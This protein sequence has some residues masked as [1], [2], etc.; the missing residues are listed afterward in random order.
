MIVGR[1]V[2]SD[3]GD[4]GTPAGRARW[5]GSLGLPTLVVGAYLV[6]GWWR[7]WTVDDAFINYRVVRQVLAGNGPV[8]NI[9]ERVEATTST[10]WVVVLTV[11]DVVS[12]FSIEWSALVVEVV[13][14][15]VGMAAGMAGAVRLG[16]LIAPDGDR[17]PGR[18][19]IV[20]PVGA[21][22]Y[23]AVAGAWDWATGGL[24][25][26]LGLAWLGVSFWAVVHLVDSPAT[27]GHLSPAG[28]DDGHG[29]IT[30]H[31]GG[32]R[33][34]DHLSDDGRADSDGDG[35]GDDRRV[36]SGDGEVAGG[37]SPR[38]LVLT[39]ALVGLGVL[40]RPDFAVFSAGFAVPV[41]AVVWRQPRQ[42][43]W[44]GFVLAAV[45]A[46]ALP[47]ATQVFRMGYY[48]QLVPNPLHAKESSR[49]WWSHGWDHL[50]DFTGTY[51][52]VV[53]V[54]VTAAWLVATWWT[55]AAPERHP[56]LAG[57][58]DGR[59]GHGPSG[60]S[61]VADGSDSHV[62][63]GD[64]SHVIDGGGGHG[65]SNDPGGGG[66]GRS[67]HRAGQAR[68]DRAGRARDWRLVVG[69]VEAAAAL[70]VLG[71]ARAGG[72]YMHARLLLPAWFALL[73]PLFA[74]RAG[75]LAP[76]WRAAAAL[77][78]GAWA[79]V[80]VAAFRP[81]G[82]YDIRTQLIAAT[83]PNPV[84]AADMVRAL[85]PLGAAADLPGPGYHDFT[86]GGLATYPAA[87]GRTV[88]GTE[89][90]G[91]VGLS[92]PLDVWVHDR[93]GLADPVTARVRL[94]HRGRPGHE[95]ILAGPWIAAM[96]VD[97]SVPLPGDFAAVNVFAAQSAGVTT[98][99]RTGFGA[100]RAAA[101]A[102]LRCGELGEL[103]HDTRAPLDVGRFVGNVV[104]AVKLH[105]ATFPADPLAARAELC[106]PSDTDG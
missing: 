62:A 9:G 92:A 13:L 99:P 70:H 104:D 86:V 3:V 79:L 25:N 24:E 26:G 29:G 91:I 77:A 80:A 46:G 18:R 82:A 85:P 93:L 73:L 75:T 69:G 66:S 103:V 14:G 6:A 48:A 89:T 56:G 105:G 10:L 35:D 40:V 17:A 51:W 101:A 32:E 42:S 100:D 12:P 90:L 28:E 76:R 19:G 81:S 55:S 67:E 34:V 54:A 94:E 63:D 65:D 5:A 61:H 31:I 95:K 64:D 8:F 58:G 21:A 41:V 87:E 45:A 97:P 72:D 37:P 11:L 68:G 2:R 84:T 39:A 20:V 44:R 22:A 88:T 98:A 23:L 96:F 60:D 83:G 36:E 50:A 38:R 33:Q 106:G 15:A 16:D 7:R 30:G 49:S 74:V 71:M 43:R 47:V 59:A 27:P 102:A 1:A 4:A 78:I 53:P 57:N 52:L